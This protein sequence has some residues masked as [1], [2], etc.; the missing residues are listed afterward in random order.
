MKT[1]A[2]YKGQAISVYAIEL[3]H[4]GDRG[5]FEVFPDRE[6]ALDVEGKVGELETRGYDVEC[7]SPE[8]LIF[9]GDAGTELTLYPDGRL[10]LE[11]LRPGSTAQAIEVAAAI[12]G[13][14]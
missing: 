7:A 12:I 4:Y 3:C 13:Y 6:L 5:D 2:T 8:V 9:H 10:I 11:G 14:T 1:A